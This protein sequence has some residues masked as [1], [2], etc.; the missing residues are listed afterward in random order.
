MTAAYPHRRACTSE[1]TLVL[2][3]VEIDNPN[4]GLLEKIKMLPRL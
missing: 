2:K 1:N 4:D 3:S